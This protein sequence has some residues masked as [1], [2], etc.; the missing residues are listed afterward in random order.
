MN[1]KYVPCPKCGRKYLKLSTLGYDTCEKCR[2]QASSEGTDV[3]A[4]TGCADDQIWKDHD[5]EE[6]SR[7]A[8]KVLSVCSTSK[9]KKS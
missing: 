9:E 2:E 6:L 3:D 5:A 8:R 4:L 7:A 1:L